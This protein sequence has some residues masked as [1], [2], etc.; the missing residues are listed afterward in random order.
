[1]A[2]KRSRPLLKLRVQGPGIRAGAIPVPYLIRI[3]QAAQEAVNRQAEAMRGGQSLRPG[4]K[5]AV[6]Y[7]ECTLELTGIEKGS[8]VLPFVLA[9]PQQPLPLP[10]VTTFGRDVVRQVTTAVK[11]LG[12]AKVS[13]DIHFEPGLLDSLR[14]MGEVLNKDVTKIDWIVP[15]NGKRALK[16]TFDKRVNERV[17]KRIK[18]PST[19]PHTVEGVLEMA[20]FKEQDHKCRVHP[21][22]GQPIVCTFRPE[23]EQEVYEALRKPVRIEGTATVNPNSG[24][25]ESVAIGKIGITEQL[26]IGAKE[27]FAGR[28]LEQ[29][30]EAQGVGPMA[31]P[32]VLAGGWPEEEDIDAFL[33]DVYSSRGA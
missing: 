25:V 16:A 32:K 13:P 7:Q 6:V 15:G 18:S 17:M 19:R 20:D 24:K 23:Q 10:E 33:E 4:P 12:S 5:S 29:L 28:S 14:G 26:L 8:A 31:N 2:T 22:V 9:K 30:A 27:F 3:C 1:M 21:L 11:S